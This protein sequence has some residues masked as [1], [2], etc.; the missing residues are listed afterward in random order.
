ML[1][2]N[3]CVDATAQYIEGRCTGVSPTG[4][5]S[6]GLHCVVVLIGVYSVTTG[7]PLAGVINQPFAVQTDNM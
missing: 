6:D 1:Q 2:F 4:I 7:L 5:H 3:L